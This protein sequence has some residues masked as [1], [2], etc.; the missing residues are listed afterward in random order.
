MEEVGNSERGEDYSVSSA[1]VR[2]TMCCLAAHDPSGFFPV[3]FV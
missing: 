1:E 3:V 2:N